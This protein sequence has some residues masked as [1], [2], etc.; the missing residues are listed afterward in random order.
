MASDTLDADLPSV[1][2]SNVGSG[3]AKAEPDSWLISLLIIAFVLR[4]LGLFQG[5]TI[6]WEGIE[7]ASIAKNLLSA[8]GYYGMIAPGKDLM[9]PPLFPMLIAVTS[10]ATHDVELAARIVSLIAGSL[11]VLPVF[12]IAGHLYDRRSARV[13]AALVAV[14][15]LLVVFSATTY[16]ESVYTT[17]LAAAVYSSLR[18][19][20]LRASRSSLAAGTFFGLAYLTRPEAAACALLASCFILVYLLTE[21]PRNVPGATVCAAWVLV[22]FVVVA[23]PYVLWLHAQTGQWRLEGKSPLNYE[24]GREMAA[25]VPPSQAMFGVDDDLTERGV[26]I[27]SNVASIRSI[28]IVPGEVLQYVRARTNDVLGFLRENLINGG[29]LGSPPLFIFVVL[30][31]FRTPWN[32]ELAANHVFLILL[33]AIP[34]SAILFI[35]YV[36]PRFLIMLVPFLIVWA[37]NGILSLAEW[38]ESTASAVRGGLR[39]KR[40]VHACLPLAL[41]ALIPLI[42]LRPLSRYS[43]VTAFAAESQP[44]K[45]AGEWLKQYAAGGSDMVI[46][47]SMVVAFYASAPFVPYPYTNSDTA[48]RFL[49][50]RGVRFVVLKDENLSTRPYL[51]AWMSNGVPSERAKLIYD[52]ETAAIG[53]IKI[54]EWH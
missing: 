19:F 40:W 23:S 47:T 45:T 52:V 17:L 34:A 31:L 30:G 6:E 25:G 53:R 10:L 3:A 29:I 54:Y 20:R 13:A 46:D 49:D 8:H 2:S 7:Y 22:P 15:P 39:P 50:E 42:V 33:L 41:A 21:R 26:F 18:A 36:E 1:P 16:S 51:N 32:R 43:D 11:L 44:I 28:R 24:T 12:L 5:R 35:F 27:R 37:A 38:A 48:L 14:H 9:F 4:L